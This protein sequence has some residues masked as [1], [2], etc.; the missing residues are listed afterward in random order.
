MTGREECQTADRDDAL[1]ALRDRFRLPPDVIYLDGNSLGPLV[2][3]V[4]D[5]MTSAVE[6]EWGEGLIR[7]WNTAGWIDLAEGVAARIEALIGAPQTTVAVG[8][9]TSVNLFKVVE[10]AIGLRPDRRFVVTDRGNFPTDLYVLSGV[11]QR[12]GLVLEVV[13]PTDVIEA[14]CDDTAVVSLTEVDYR[15]G[16]RHDMRRVTEAA[17]SA[18]AL[19]VWDLAHS[20]G[21]FPVAVAEN[22]VDFAV[23]CGYK[24]LNGGPGAP[25]FLYVAPGLADGWSNPIRGWFGHARPFAFELEF[26]PA[27]GV[28]R[29]QIGT[30]PILSMVALH[31]SLSVFDGVDLVAVRAKSL[32][33]TDLFIELV[34]EYLP[35][36]TIVTP[37]EH[38]RRGSQVSLRHPEGYSI[39]QALIARGVIGDFRAPDILRFGFAPLYVGFEDTFRAVEQ[40][41]EVM[42]GEEWR[43]PRF[44]AVARVT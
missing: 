44:A 7:S 38:E 17:H 1:R 22:A 41:R 24:Y 29:G 2:E 37:R 8:D 18:G 3:T 39:V 28:I 12:A 32:A 6:R 10:A 16:R 26:E 31:E 9:S 19:A 23:G 34:G 40:L 21:A 36:F 14:I 25:G 11:C 5:R 13:E 33:L 30:P 35:D 27:E 15:T 42:S 20:A 4:P 43:D